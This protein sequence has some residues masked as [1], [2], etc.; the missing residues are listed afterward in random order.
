[1]DRLRGLVERRDH[2]RVDAAAARVT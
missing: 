2:E 1:M